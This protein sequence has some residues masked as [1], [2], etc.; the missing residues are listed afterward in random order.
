M[1]RVA[2]RV[3]RRDVRGERLVRRAL[4]HSHEVVIDA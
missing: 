1:A 2:A 3:A 4:E